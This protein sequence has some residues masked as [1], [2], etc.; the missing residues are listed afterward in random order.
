[1]RDVQITDNSE[2]QRYEARTDGQ[3]VGYA[4]HR[5][6]P[7]RLVI[8]HVEVDPASG[9]HGIGTR[10]VE[11][12]LADARSRDLTVVPRCSFAAAVMSGRAHPNKDR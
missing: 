1:M 2:A 9:G 10:L 3:V 4:S 11:H 6:E 5:H 8:L 12:A 7:G